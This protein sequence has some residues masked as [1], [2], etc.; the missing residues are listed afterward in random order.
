MSESIQ[1]ALRLIEWHARFEPRDDP[2]IIRI[3]VAQLTGCENLR[4][5]Y[6]RPLFREIESAWV[7]T[8]HLKRLIIEG[9][10]LADDTLLS[11]VA[12]L[13]QAVA[14]DGDSSPPI[15]FIFARKSASYLR[16][17][18]EH[19]KEGR[20]DHLAAQPFRLA[21]SNQVEIDGAPRVAILSYGLWQRRY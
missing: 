10:C 2:Q 5:P 1:L 15:F 4:Y 8:N 9:D 18:F 19:R 14:E 6:I 11:P 13:P 21:C 17:H 3:H 7:H 16:G 12:A 20:G